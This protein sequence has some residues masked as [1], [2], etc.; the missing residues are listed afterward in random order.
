M[1]S[2]LS[3]CGLVAQIISLMLPITLRDNMESMVAYFRDY[4]AQFFSST[5]VHF[6]ILFPDDVPTIAI[7]PE[8][9]RNLLLVIKESLNNI[10]KHATASA[11]MVELKI[12][13][14]HVE[15]I[16]QD[17][18]KGFDTNEQKKFSNGLKN[19]R[20]R[21]E[22]VGGSFEV[23]SKIGKGTETRIAFKV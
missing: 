11:V 13:A 18:G 21:M 17:S 6:T 23:I 4:I 2:I 20:K 3:C 15:I 7:A 5:Q 10:L 8:L 12:M 16:I 22:E 1:L 14:G 19:M 9:R